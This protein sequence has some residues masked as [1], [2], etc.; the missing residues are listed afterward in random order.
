MVVFRLLA[1][2]ARIDKIISQFAKVGITIR[3]VSK[4]YVSSE[5]D[6]LREVDV[7]IRGSAGYSYVD[8]LIKDGT[9]VQIRDVRDVERQNKE[10]TCI[11]YALWTLV[12]GV[13]ALLVL[14][15]YK[16]FV[17]CVG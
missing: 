6:I 11:I 2:A 1:R 13:C 12:G 5:K 10:E 3:R 17:A 7:C 8:E 14:A 15:A 4:P 16:I 9:V